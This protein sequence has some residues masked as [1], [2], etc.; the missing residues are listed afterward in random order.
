MAHATEPV[1]P[2]PTSSPKNKYIQVCTSPPL[3]AF[4]H[5]Y[6]EGPNARAPSR[7]NS[8]VYAG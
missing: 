3:A 5:S 6:Q 8:I 2:T 4:L 1:T 7:C